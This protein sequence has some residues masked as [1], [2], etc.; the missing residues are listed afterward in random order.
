MLEKLKNE[1]NVQNIEEFCQIF[2]TQKTLNE[3]LYK[4]SDTMAEEVVYFFKK[5]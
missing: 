2:E 4:K 3:E 1:A 5:F